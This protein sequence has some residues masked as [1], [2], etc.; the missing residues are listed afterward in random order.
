MHIICQKN[1]YWLWY[2]IYSVSVA[3]SLSGLRIDPRWIKWREGTHAPR[4]F[5]HGNTVAPCLAR[6][7]RDQ[8][9]DM[10]QCNSMTAKEI[11]DAVNR[12][13]PL[14]GRRGNVGI[15]RAVRMRLAT[16]FHGSFRTKKKK[17]LAALSLVL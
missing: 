9:Q 13:R 12:K 17:T 11:A 15:L 14:S 3:F 7:Q 10:L 2:H 8:M 4:L 6:S 5:L 1:I 16:T